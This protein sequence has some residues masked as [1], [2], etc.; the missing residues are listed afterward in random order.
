MP[1]MFGPNN[2]ESPVPLSVRYAFMRVGENSMDP[3][4]WTHIQS[5]FSFEKKSTPVEPKV[6]F[7]LNENLVFKTEYLTIRIPFAYGT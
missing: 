6:T 5:T 2:N 7:N 1:A 3:T 4:L